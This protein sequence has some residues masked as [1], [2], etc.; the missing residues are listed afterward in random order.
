MTP[1]IFAIDEGFPVGVLEANKK[2]LPEAVLIPCLTVDPRIEGMDDWELL[3][4]L[5]NHRKPFAGLVTADRRMLGDPKT[6]SVLHQLK[7][8][9]V[10]AEGAGS[11]PI[12]A[13]AIMLAHL[14]TVCVETD[15]GVA[16]V[17]VLNAGGKRRAKSPFDYLKRA[18]DKLSTSPNALYNENKLGP[19]ELTVSPI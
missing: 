13:S 12:L 9:L 7:L 10:V 15:P 16:Q 19:Q 3:R 11:D 1:A 4:A 14:P 2:F 6:L 8:T 18:A 17:W 5:R